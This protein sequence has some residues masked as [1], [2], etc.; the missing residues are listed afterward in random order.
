MSCSISYGSPAGL[1][2]AVTEL[3]Q[4]ACI[5]FVRRKRSRTQCRL[6]RLGHEER[7]PSSMICNRAR[8]TSQAR[9]CPQ[10]LPVDDRHQRIIATH[11]QEHGRTIPLA[12]MQQPQV[13]RRLRHS[14]DHLEMLTNIVG[15]GC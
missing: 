14:I 3:M 8:G 6:L 10:D 5:S 15:V 7:M 13:C 4:R 11:G 12:D 2:K 1:I 9:I